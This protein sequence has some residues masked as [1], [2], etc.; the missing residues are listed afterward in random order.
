MY[1]TLKFQPHLAEQVRQGTKVCTWRLFDDKNLQVGDL[2]ELYE[3]GSDVPFA[4]A[5]ITRQVEKPL[6][7][8]EEED[9]EG[10]ERFA[11]DKEMYATYRAYYGPRVGPKTIVKILWFD[12]LS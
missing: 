2:I 9:W 8:L 1:K 4:K 7:K 12:L 6:G 10:H 3:N 5:T 11:N